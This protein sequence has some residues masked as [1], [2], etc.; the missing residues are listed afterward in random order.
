MGYVDIHGHY[1][2][3][4]DDGISTK[5][6]A[7]QALAL[8]REQGISDIVAT[9]HFTSG[10]MSSDIKDIALDR[11]NELKE[12]ARQFDINVYSGCELM[13]NEN[14]TEVV[15]KDLFLPIENTH[16][17]LCEY[18][19]IKPTDSFMEHFD[20]YLRAIIKKGYIPIVAHIERYFHS[21]LDIDYVQYLIDLGCV[22]QVNTTSILDKQSLHHKN[23]MT[24]LDRNMVHVIGTDTHR[25][26]GGRIPNMQEC[27]KYLVKYGYPKAYCQLLMDENAHQIL[28]DK[29][30]THPKYK[31]HLIK[32]ML[33][34]K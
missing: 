12:L 29:P 25:A 7:E 2:W 32:K 26:Q 13:L 22:I 11:I 6:E 5:N 4:I 24:L 17:V 14:S 27:Y 31:R 23:A 19:V 9:P 28:L 33:H 21:V 34:H 15:E 18:N 10:F 30:T 1:A 16:Y 3:D 20:D 8:A